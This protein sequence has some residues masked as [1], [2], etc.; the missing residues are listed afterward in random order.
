MLFLIAL[1]IA[2]TSSATVRGPLTLDFQNWLDRNGYTSFDFVRKDYG[3]QGSYGG[4]TSNNSN[5]TKTPVIFVHGNSDSALKTTLFATGW[6][7]SIAYFEKQGYTSSELYVTSWQDN[8]AAKAATRTHNCKDLTRLRKFFE[9]V[10]AYTGAVK[11]SVVSHSMGVTLARKLIQGGGVKA[12][13]GNCDLGASISDKIDVLVAIS[14]ANYGLCNCGG[15]LGW[16]SATCNKNNGFWPGDFCGAYSSAFCGLSTVR[17]NEPSTYSHL[18]SEMNNSKLKEASKVFSLWSKADD[19]IG[20][21]DLVWG[22]PTSLVPLS[23]GTIIY[24]SFTHM[25]SKEKTAEDQYRLV[26]MGKI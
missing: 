22:R 1:L 14:G 9:A 24:K 4:F 11:V 3:T 15:T 12:T 23:D 5:A 25:Q 2:T 10:L 26:V 20:N 19:L 6:D 18:L 8:N 21:G 17:C 13:D 7:N 16:F